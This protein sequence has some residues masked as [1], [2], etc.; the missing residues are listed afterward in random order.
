MGT[1]ER[2]NTSITSSK[3]SV[4]IVGGGIVGLM[5]AY[6]MLRD[7]WSVT[8]LDKGDFSDNCSHGNAGM[9]VPS[10]FTPMAAP[11]VVSQGI[12]WMFDAR[13]PF[14]I[15]PTLDRSLASW[16]I[17]FMKHANKSHVT[18]SAPYILALNQRSKDL[19]IQLANELGN[20]FELTHNGILMLYKT[21]KT[22]VEEIH[23]AER[24]KALGVEVDV[25]NAE[26]VQRLEPDIRLDVLG[27][28]HYRSDSHINPNAL[29][30]KLKRQLIQSGANLVSGAEVVNF[31]TEKGKI[32]AAQTTTDAY[33]ADLFV[34]TGGAWLS[35]IG[36]L[37]G[38][39]IPLM[40]GKGYSFQTPLFDGK[41]RHPSLLL[42]ARVAIT[43]MGGLVRVGG[44][45]ELAPINHRINPNR[46][47]GIVRAVPSYYPDQKIPTPEAKNIW[48]GFRP[49]SPDGL[50]YLGRANKFDNVI[51]AGGMGMMGLSL[52]PVAG[53]I[54]SQLANND[55]EETD[56][57]V[58]NP[59]RFH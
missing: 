51:I 18:R 30:N 6:Y 20:S 37:A 17:K 22:A 46:V 26:E 27:A 45:M 57:Q 55:K 39:R 41:L 42:E 13:S 47:E 11:G 8:V 23:L 40:P 56:I 15:K 1:I 32:K 49:C 7:G 24:A 4:V 14:Y 10:H 33:G 52:G 34:L 19:Y 38:L 29:I 59:L 9:I 25:L 35:T 58:F 43:P 2:N 16:G 44:T 50:P 31:V 54:V 28:T 48:H 53:K 5:S 36:K 3:G 12:K 21:E